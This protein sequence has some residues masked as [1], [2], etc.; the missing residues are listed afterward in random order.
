L[1]S[2]IKYLDSIAIPVVKNLE[3]IQDVAKLKTDKLIN[4]YS[5]KSKNS[6]NNL[7]YFND[8]SSIFKNAN[9]S[10]DLNLKKINQ[11]GFNIY[12]SSESLYPLPL[13]SSLSIDSKL[14]NKISSLRIYGLGNLTTTYIS[15]NSNIF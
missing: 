10:V 8:I 14:F 15:Q 13:I 6:L 5:L 3:T 4:N 1:L 11:D 7:E 12:S 2:D 9:K